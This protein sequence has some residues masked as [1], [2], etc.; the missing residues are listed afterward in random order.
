MAGAVTVF[1]L[2]LLISSQ[3]CPAQSRK[4]LPDSI[5]GSVENTPPPVV[6]TAVTLADSFHVSAS[7]DAAGHDSSDT[8]RSENSPVQ[9]DSVVFRA[10]PDSVFRRLKNDKDF[11]Y[12]N[13][14]AYWT[15]EKDNK[16]ENH[17]FRFLE[18]FL[19]S[20]G[21]KYFVYFLLAA[22]LFYALYRI[23]AENDLRFFYKAGAKAVNPAGEAISMKEEDLEEGLQRAM[24][25][26]DHRLAVRY[27]YLK[28][29]RRLDAKELIRYHAQSTNQEYISQLGGLPQQEPF[30]LLTRVY[31]RVWYGDFAINGQQFTSLQTY[32]KDFDGSLG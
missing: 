19:N 22:I 17:S 16:Q 8:S 27:L 7:S 23:I 10:V 4:R 11:A 25:I 2:L 18:N 29:L 32:F 3:S 28:A 12:A 31:E 20:Q 13:D 21:F 1:L 26:P 14:P 30:R 5:P 9:H 24:G 15:P 6:D